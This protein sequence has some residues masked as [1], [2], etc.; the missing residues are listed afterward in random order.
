MFLQQANY[1]CHEDNGGS[2]D[3]NAFLSVCVIYFTNR[4]YM[5]VMSKIE[6][7]IL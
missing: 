7:N 1:T 5:R 4:N 3:W 2:R 6:Y